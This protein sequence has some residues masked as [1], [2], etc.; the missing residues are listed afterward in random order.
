[1]P[2]ATDE[3]LEQFNDS[4]NRCTAKGDFTEK[5]YARFM[6]ASPAAAEKFRGVDMRKQQR[7]LRGSLY[8]MLSAAH[9]KSDGLEHLDQIARQHSRSDRDI[10]PELYDVWLDSLIETV[11]ESDPRATPEV[12]AAWR[13]V[14]R[15]GIEF[16]KAR[17]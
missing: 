4:L 11:R 3:Q 15:A 14:L 16:M 10:G 2:S 17:Y 5:F 6:T 12:E 13:A 7:M 9:G 1:M 8:M